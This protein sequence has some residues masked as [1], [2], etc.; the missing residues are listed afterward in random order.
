MAGCLKLFL[1]FQRALL[2]YTSHPPLQLARNDP[3]G[4]KAIEHGE[5]TRIKGHRSVNNYKKQF[6]TYPH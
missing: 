3:V 4:Q 5:A 6:P 1:F 2:D